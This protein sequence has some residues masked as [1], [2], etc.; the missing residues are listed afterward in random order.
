V[1]WAHPKYESIL[2]SCGYDKK[3]NIWKEVK[4]PGT[5][6]LVYQFEA[7]ASVNS[8]CWAP[9]EYGLVLAAGSADGR[10]HIISRKGDDT[11]NIVSFE[12]HNGGVNAISWGPS[13]DPAMLS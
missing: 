6:D 5:W 4:A 9:W 2:A 8:I 11:W 10:I 1:T 7:A 13:T 12:G 3:I